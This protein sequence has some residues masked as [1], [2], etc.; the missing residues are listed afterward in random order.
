M[1][2]LES[3]GV[4]LATHHWCWNAQPSPEALH[5]RD[6]WSFWRLKDQVKNITKDKPILSNQPFDQLALRDR[7]AGKKISS[8]S[9]HVG[10]KEFRFQLLTYS[11]MERL[12]SSPS[13]RQQGFLKKFRNPSKDIT[14]QQTHFQ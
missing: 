3:L 5:E 12:S 2:W 8:N 14:R 11:L 7:A 6:S 4:N 13:F 9:A 1:L 10:D